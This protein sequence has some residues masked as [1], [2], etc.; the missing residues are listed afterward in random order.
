MVKFFGCC[1]LGLNHLAMSIRIHVKKR[2]IVH[3]DEISVYN[4]HISILQ[5]TNGVINLPDSCYWLFEHCYCLLLMTKH[6]TNCHPL[7]SY[8]Y[9]L[10]FQK[11]N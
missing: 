11:L 3:R 9:S 10:L 6:L 8:P 4:Y 2:I 1:W 7:D 5:Y